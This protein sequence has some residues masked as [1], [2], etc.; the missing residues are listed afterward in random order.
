MASGNTDFGEGSQH[1]L[2]NKS[3]LLCQT[4]Q[5]TWCTLSIC[6]PPGSLQFATYQAVAAYRASPQHKSWAL[7]LRGPSWLPTRHRSLL[8][9]PGA[10]CV[11]PLGGLLEACTWLPLNSTHAPFPCTGP[12]LCTFFV[13]DHSHEYHYITS[14]MILRLKH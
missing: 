1:S 7:G 12:A 3:G 11:T 10:S 8:R 14:A 9:E 13:V 4:I 5:I 6:F 2:T